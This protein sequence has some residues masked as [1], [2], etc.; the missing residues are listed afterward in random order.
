M[1]ILDN[2]KEVAKAV[3]EIHNLELYHRV[4]A[5]HSDIIELV[6]ENNRIRDENKA[7]TKTIALKQKM[8]FTEPFYYQEGDKTPYCP[9]CWE[10]KD[11]AIHL[12]LAFD[13]TEYTRWDCPSCKHNYLME[14]SL[15]HRKP[16]RVTPGGLNS[17]MG[18]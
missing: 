14:K 5:L 2:A 13:N 17:W 6:E 11:S 1:G 10:G 16:T 7:L 4:L 15:G 18:S 3:Q 9:A 8:H 12:F